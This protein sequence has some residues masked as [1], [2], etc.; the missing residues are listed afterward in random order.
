[1]VPCLCAC[2]L[3]IGDLKAAVEGAGAILDA[4]GD[5]KITVS[6]RVGMGQ[7]LLNHPR[8][9]QSILFLALF[10]AP[11]SSCFTFTVV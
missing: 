11:V 2:F 3:D 8:I 1:M 5:G 6:G 4:N 9:A 7:R 10:L